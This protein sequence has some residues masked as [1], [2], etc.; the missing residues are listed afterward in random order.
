VAIAA[1]QK[2]VAEVRACAF[3]QIGW[4]MSYA[5]VGLGSPKPLGPLPQSP[6]SNLRQRS[7]PVK[8]NA[9]ALKGRHFF[10]ALLIFFED[11][12]LSL[13]ASL[14]GFAAV[15]MC[16]NQRSPVIQPYRSLSSDRTW[17]EDPSDR[18]LP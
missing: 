7:P 8:K 11:F 15:R 12:A 9:F 4:Q 10:K 18:T 6:A 14:R 16:Q 5:E 2:A 3:A 17:N 1:S 13:C